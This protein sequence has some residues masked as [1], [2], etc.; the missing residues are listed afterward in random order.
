MYVLYTTCMSICQYK[1]SVLTDNRFPPRVLISGGNYEDRQQL[2]VGTMKT[3]SYYWWELW[4]Q[5]AT[6]GGNYEDRQQLL[7][8]TMKT[9]SYYWWELWRQAATTGGNY[10]DRQQLLVGTMKTGSYYWWELWRQA[11]T[12]GGNYEDRQLLLVGKADLSLVCTG[13]GKGRGHY[14]LPTRASLT[15]PTP[16]FSHPNYI[17]VCRCTKEN[18]KYRRQIQNS[19]H[20]KNFDSV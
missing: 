8:G 15:Y 4:R 14:L 16:Q 1:D 2:L 7:V 13:P 9:G 20:P 3:G 5:A 17:P 10:E 11:A 18:L 19:I 6:T 12:T